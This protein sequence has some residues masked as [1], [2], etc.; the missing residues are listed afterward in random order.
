[1]PI[2]TEVLNTTFADL[3]GPLVNS[4]VRS[5]ELFEALDKKARMPMEGG[6]L[7]ERSFTGGAPARGV[8]IY[9]GDELLNMT[10]RQQ[11]KKFQVEPHRIVVAVNIPKKELMF[12][13]GK[14]AI[15]RLIE[16]YPKTVMDGVKADLNKYFLTGVSRGIVFQTSEL[17]GFLTLNGQVSTGIGTGVTNGLLDFAT[18]ATQ[19]DVVQGVAK[20]SSYFHFN[21]FGDMAAAAFDIS[22]LRKTYRECAHYAGGMGKGPDLVYM[23]QDVYTQFEE[24][25]SSNFRINV[26]TMQDG[27]DGNNN[28]IELSLGLAKVFS[29][30]DLDNADFTSP[31]DN[32]VTYILNTDYLEMPVHEAPQMSEFRER[33]GD[34]D[35][36]TAVFSMQANLI[37]TKVPAHGCVSGGKGS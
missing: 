10:R 11:I 29:S 23:D 32:G 20:S 18:P 4:F 1:M 35:V 15:M 25:Q 31:A 21:Q 5:N 37:A 30:I 33:V 14:L 12:N 2:S 24:N 8:G 9:V 27:V 6:S 17:R 19:T 16:E 36:V 34:Q 13:S 7:I 22:D 28:T 26:N 3:R